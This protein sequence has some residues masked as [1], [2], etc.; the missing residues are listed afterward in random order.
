[1]MNM[2]QIIYN[3]TYWFDFI[4]L[5]ARHHPLVSV[6]TVLV[7]FVFYQALSVMKFI[8][9]IFSFGLALGMAILLEMLM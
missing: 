9:A 4:M 3:L 6:A 7:A 2:N 5:V 8:A 1:M